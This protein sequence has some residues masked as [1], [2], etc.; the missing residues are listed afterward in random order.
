MVNISLK[1]LLIIGFPFLF[2][3][4]QYIFLEQLVIYSCRFSH[5]MDCFPISLFNVLLCL[6]HFFTNLIIACSAPAPTLQSHLTQS[7][8]HSTQNRIC[9][10]VLRMVFWLLSW[11]VSFLGKPYL[12]RAGTHH[13]LLQHFFSLK[14]AID[15]FVSK[16]D[17]CNDHLKWVN[18]MNPIHLYLIKCYLI[19]RR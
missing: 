4:L 3:S 14:L 18:L 19:Q 17:E 8:L 6:L 2:F 16:N 11:T 15:H 10:P 1:Y 5:N 9:S 7:C 13:M 12:T